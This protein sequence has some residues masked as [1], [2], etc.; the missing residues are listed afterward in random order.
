MFSGYWVVGIFFPNF[1]CLFTSNNVSTF[2]LIGLHSQKKIQV[3][4][5]INCFF[6]VI[7]KGSLCLRGDYL[8]IMFVVVAKDG[9][10]Q[11]FHI[12]FGM[13]VENNLDCCTWFLMRLKESLGKGREV[14]LKSNMDD[15]ITSYINHVFIDSYHGVGSGRSLQPLLWMTLKVYTMSIFEQKFS[16]LSCD[17]REVLTNIGHPK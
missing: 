4:A 13:A 10:N 17:A 12:P 1:Y 14:V 7:V 11:N 9:N 3:H 2:K 16:R 15:V 8:K 5:F 6:P